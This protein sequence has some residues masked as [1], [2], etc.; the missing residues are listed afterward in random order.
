MLVASKGFL[1][2]IAFDGVRHLIVWVTLHDIRARFFRPDGVLDGPEI[3][4]SPAR[5]A[6]PVTVAWDGTHFVVAWSG[7]PSGAAVVAANG[8]VRPLPLFENGDRDV[9]EDVAAVADGR[10]VVVTYV[11][12]RW[13]GR[14]AIVMARVVDGSVVERTVPCAPAYSILR[15][16]IAPAPWGYLLSWTRGDDAYV[17]L[18]TFIARLNAHGQMI[19]D[20]LPI[21]VAVIAMQSDVP[22]FDGRNAHVLIEDGGTLDDCVITEA[23]FRGA[24]LVRK[25]VLTLPNSRPA[26]DI[27]PLTHDGAIAI[28]Y[29]SWSLREPVDMTQVTIV[30]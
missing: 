16:R 21:T 24:P 7:F 15:P 19:G 4:V 11:R 12:R 30:Q 17:H 8:E 9:D 10:G 29:V 14:N 2:S 23:T 18:T 1:P 25:R 13:D 5:F 22:Y 20:P 6:K 28:A 3:V 26:R 27:T